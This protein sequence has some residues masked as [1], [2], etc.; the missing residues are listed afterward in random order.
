M[1][2]QFKE[3]QWEENLGSVNRMKSSLI[4]RCPL[5]IKVQILNKIYAS[6]KQKGEVKAKLLSIHI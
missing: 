1:E 6:L 5:D 3:R 4:L 2:L